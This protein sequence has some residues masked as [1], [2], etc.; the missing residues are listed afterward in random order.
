MSTKHKASDILKV[1]EKGTPKQQKPTEN[2]GTTEE[3]KKPDLIRKFS[4]GGDAWNKKAAAKRK[5]SSGLKQIIDII[6]DEEDEGR[7]SSTES[8]TDKDVEGSQADPTEVA[9]DDSINVVVRVRPLN[10]SETEKRDPSTVQFPGDGVLLVNS[11]GS[12]KP[13]TF[14]VLFEPEASQKDVFEHSGVKKLVAMAVDGYACT[15]FAFGQTGSGKTH[16]ITGPPQKTG[17]KLEES[18]YGLI[19]RSF[20]NLLSLISEGESKGHSYTLK[21]SYFELYNE[22]ILDLLN[23]QGGR[24]LN[25]RWSANKG[26]YIE[27]L[28][29][30]QC[31]TFDDLMAVLE[32][33]LNN[34]STSA[35]NMND[36]SSRSHSMLTINIESEQKDAVDENLYITKHGKLTFVDLAGSEK[37]KDTNTSGDQLL[38]TNN[39]NKSLLVLG[40]CISA[41]GDAKKRNGHIPYRDSKLTKLLSDSIGGSSVTLMIACVSPSKS[42]QGE[43]MNTLRYATR[44]KKI[45]N[46]PVVK[47][48][49]R[50]S[51]I[52]TLKKE[53]KVLK[54]ENQLLRDHSHTGDGKS[55]T[56]GSRAKPDGASNAKAVDTKTSIN[57][58]AHENTDLYEMLQEYMVENETL[59]SENEEHLLGRDRLKKDQQYIVRENDR[60]QKKVEELQRYILSGEHVPVQSIQREHVPVQSIQSTR[61]NS[62]HDT[63]SGINSASSQNT[64]RSYHSVPDVNQFSYNNPSQLLYSPQPPVPYHQNLMPRL[65]PVKQ[66]TAPPVIGQY[67]LSPSQVAYQ[68]AYNK[69]YTNPSPMMKMNP[70]PPPKIPQ[71]A[72]F[73]PN[74]YSQ[75]FEVSKSLGARNAFQN[76]PHIPGKLPGGQLVYSSSPQLPLKA[77]PA[78]YSTLPPHGSYGNPSL[79]PKPPYQAPSKHDGYSQPGKNTQ[80]NVNDQ[81][82]QELMM[83][84]GEIRHTQEALTTTR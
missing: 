41:L 65:P 7:G 59:R 18:D 84:E 76:P 71:N 32:E 10:S 61:Q 35:H 51:F 77:L 48:D 54:A 46:K 29:T 22:Q 79:Q 30:I 31:E 75:K 21:A 4:L 33:G 52:M 81:L 8:P 1:P 57:S 26:F 44:T 23:P 73:A 19:P 82:K 55:P 83:L 36:F 70:T 27:N 42:N 38:E 11:N 13:F 67:S 39:I 40:K 58:F 17:M 74:S 69:A 14:N 2:G 50:E 28:F 64:L 68:N 6:D 12:L 49:P 25:M 78:P 43:T 80:Y 66:K 47:M 20:H 37:V 24:K 72:S 45:K 9:G 3:S 62:W 53:I 16:S 5:V 60:L 15:C 34:K 63:H 56:D